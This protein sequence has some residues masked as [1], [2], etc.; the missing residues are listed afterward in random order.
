MIGSETTPLLSLN[1]V[2]WHTQTVGIQEA[3][4][5][6]RDDVALVGRETPPFLS[7]RETLLYTMAVQI[8]FS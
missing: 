2:L 1:V 4:I 6:L 8:E 3:E 7:F 5:V